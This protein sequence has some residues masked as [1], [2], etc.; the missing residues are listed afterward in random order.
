MAVRYEEKMST[1]NKRAGSRRLQYAALPFRCRAHASVQVMLVTSRET[2]RWVVPKGWPIA[3]EAPHVSAAR[4]AIEEAGVVGIVGRDSIGMYSYEKRLASGAIV[5]CEVQVFPLKVERQHED[6]PE[7]E[8]REFQWFS[9]TDAA[10]V[11]QEPELECDHTQYPQFRKIKAIS[12]DDGAARW[13]EIR[14]TA[15]AGRW[16]KWPSGARPLAAVPPTASP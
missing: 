12:L 7:K 3:G 2:G 9:P 1:P 5:I 15:L 4:E 10:N 16:G 11:V 6:W 8:Q 14:V 13:N